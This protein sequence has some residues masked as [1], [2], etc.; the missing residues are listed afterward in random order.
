M[1]A[2]DFGNLCFNSGASEQNILVVI[3]GKNMFLSMNDFITEAVNFL[4]SDGRFCGNWTEIYKNRT[5]LP[6]SAD[7]IAW[8]KSRL[9]EMNQRVNILYEPIIKAV[10]V[11]P[12]KWNDI[13]LGIETMNEYILYLWGT[14][15]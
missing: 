10:N 14:S 7:D 11:V 15:A 1:I 9:E 3:S 4:E 2:F 8:M 12:S 13:T 5:N 6:A